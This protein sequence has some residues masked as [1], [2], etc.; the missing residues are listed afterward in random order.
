MDE[1]WGKPGGGA[2]NN[3]NRLANFEDILYS[4]RR[5]HPNFYNKADTPK[6]QPPHFTRSTIDS[7]A[8]NFYQFQN[9][10]RRDAKKDFILEHP[11][12]TTTEV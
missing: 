4:P 11:W 9:N 10:K 7:K 6:T 1:F 5:E 2:P 3:G 8:T 12:A